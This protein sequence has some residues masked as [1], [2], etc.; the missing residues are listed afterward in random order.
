MS[1]LGNISQSESWRNAMIQ[2]KLI[3]SAIVSR[4]TYEALVP[5]LQ[6]KALGDIGRLVYEGITQYYG[7]DPGADS[8]DRLLLQEQLVARYPQSE[9]DILKY[10]AEIGEG[11][12]D[13][14]NIRSLARELNKRALGQELSIALAKNDDARVQKLIAALEK[15]EEDDA[16]TTYDGAVKPSEFFGNTKGE[17]IP[18]FPLRLNEKIDGGSFRQSQV[19]VLARANVGKSSFCYNLAGGVAING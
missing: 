19:C 3:A 17:R 9:E 4:E 18:L 15:N 12:K 10:F 2:N 7:A 11:A 14:A 6:R 5:V 8:V 13:Q 16:S 1:T